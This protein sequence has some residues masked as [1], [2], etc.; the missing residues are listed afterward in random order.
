MILGNFVIILLTLFSAIN[1]GFERPN[2]WVFS[3]FVILGYS[4][5]LA[6]TGLYL[7]SFLNLGTLYFSL[8]GWYTWKEKET[9]WFKHIVY[10]NNMY[11]WFY[12]IGWFGGIALY[13]INLGKP[14][15]IIDAV[16]SILLFVGTLLL[17]EKERNF[18]WIV[19][20]FYNIL[21]IYMSAQKDD[22]IMITGHAL[23]L[24]NS[25]IFLIVWRKKV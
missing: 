22:I 21:I 10:I 13:S 17:I 11:L 19:W 3:S 20:S 25:L 24:L 12:V 9:R 18:T 15:V 14:D 4:I 6:F 2:S 7:S 5:T 8:S 1:A 23:L 16:S